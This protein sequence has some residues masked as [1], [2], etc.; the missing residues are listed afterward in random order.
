L[1]KKLSPSDIGEMTCYGKQQIANPDQPQ[2][3]KTATAPQQPPAQSPSLSDAPKHPF[4]IVNASTGYLNLRSGPG[5]SFQQIA[6]IPESS[7]V[8][9]GRCV[10]PEGLLP[11]CE[12]EWQGKSGWASSCCMAVLFSYRVTQNL[13]LRSAPDK[14]SG[15]VL[16][17]Y[18][19]KDYLPEGSI[20]SYGFFYCTYGSGL[21]SPT[22]E[23]WCRVNYDHDG[24]TTNGWVSA[25][26]L[27]DN[28]GVLLACQYATPDPE[29]AR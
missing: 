20:L 1:G 6:S 17:D 27:R 5:T 7:T 2:Q 22:H 12:V 8:L 14:N 10:K 24:I 26:F 3:A 16:S 13:M 4:R 21:Y 29:C 23:V 18:A 11:F 15:N 9:V 25:H 19:P 28:Y